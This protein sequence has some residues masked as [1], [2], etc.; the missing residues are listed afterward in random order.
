MRSA[1]HVMINRVDNRS[2]MQCLLKCNELLKQ[3]SGPTSP[4]AFQPVTPVR[5]T[6][7][8]RKQKLRYH[9]EQMP[10]IAGRGLRCRTG[11]L[12]CI[13]VEAC[14]GWGHC[15]LFMSLEVSTWVE[16][17]LRRSEAGFHNPNHG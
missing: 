5:F 2:M 8:P 17:P 4:L 14:F 16:G 1:G 12:P 9:S 15:W 11:N 6:C 3:V 13:E 10:E 7:R